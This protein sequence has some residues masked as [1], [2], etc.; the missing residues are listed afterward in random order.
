MTELTLVLYDVVCACVNCVFAADVNLYRL[1]VMKYHA[2]YKGAA[3]V[4]IPMCQ[5]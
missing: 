3:R 4:K 2:E 1:Y 5:L